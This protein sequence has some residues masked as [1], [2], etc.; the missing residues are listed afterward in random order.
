MSIA[1]FGKQK[2]DTTFDTIAKELSGAFTVNET[3]EWK[4]SAEV[5][6]GGLIAV[7][8][9]EGRESPNLDKLL[10]VGSKGQTIIDC[11]SGDVVYRNR[12]H[13]GYSHDTL[14]AW[15]LSG[16]NSDPVRMSGVGGGGLKRFTSDGWSVEAIP[17]AWPIYYYVLQH[18]GSSIFSDYKLGRKPKFD[19]LDYDYQQMAWGFSNSGNSLLLTSSSDVILWSRSR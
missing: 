1:M 15:D 9:F 18:P 2:K 10:A 12:D 4:R 13:D 16:V 3:V 17:I 14:T 6:V 5:V 11:Q 19:L 8:F 7:G